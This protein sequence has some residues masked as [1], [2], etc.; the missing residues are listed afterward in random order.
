MIPAA[1]IMSAVFRQ[2]N[3]G[4]HGSTAAQFQEFIQ[5]LFLLRWRYFYTPIRMSAQQS[6]FGQ[7]GYDEVCTRG[8]LPA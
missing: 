1:H 4:Y 3:A 6:G 8:K 2:N 5:Q 7:I